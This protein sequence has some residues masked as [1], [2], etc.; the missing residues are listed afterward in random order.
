MFWDKQLFVNPD[1]FYKKEVIMLVEYKRKVYFVVLPYIK[2][3]DYKK[4]IKD[5]LFVKK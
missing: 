2:Y 3:Y 4:F 1:I 5:I